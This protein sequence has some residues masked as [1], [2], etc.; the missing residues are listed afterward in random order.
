MNVP[1]RAEGNW[2][3]R[4]TDKMLSNRTF[5]WL[6]DLTRSANRSSPG[7][8]SVS[9]IAEGETIIQMQHSHHLSS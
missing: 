1:G 9:E 4:S 2:R 8:G 3:W 7:T 5:E 6:R